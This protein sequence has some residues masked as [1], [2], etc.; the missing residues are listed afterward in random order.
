MTTGRERYL[1]VNAD[2]FG[3]SHGVNAGVSA[4]H[5]RG[6]VTSASLMVRWP[7]ASQA[8]SYARA[9]P[10]MSVGLHVDLGEWAL[11]NGQWKALYDVVP[12]GDRDLV[13]AEVG[14][15][16]ERFR[17][18]TGRDPTHLD[19][20]QW[21]HRSEP[22]RS[23]LKELARRLTIPLRDYNAQVYYCGAFYGQDAD[24]ESFPPAITA[25]GLVKILTSL[26]PGVTELGC[27]PGYGDDVASMYRAERA[28]EVEALCDSEAREVLRAE[29]IRLCTFE[30]RPR[31]SRGVAGELSHASITP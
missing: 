7:A 25:D 12:L 16:L 2:D 21:V 30:T 31:V 15:Q 5:E 10:E 18:L 20:H 9:H 17:E 8:A 28:L 24:G 4:A 13:A 27:H 11:R 1:I 29:Q 26:S 6:I 14:H 3:L 22:V 19:S 23:V